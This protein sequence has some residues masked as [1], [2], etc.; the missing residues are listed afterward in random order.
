MRTTHGLSKSPEYRAWAGMWQRCA[1]PRNA[2]YAK[3]GGRGIAICDRWDSFEN[4]LEDMGWR[5]SPSH[6]I[7]RVD[8]NGNY[9]PENCRW[10]TRSEQQRNR[11]PYDPNVPTGDAHWTRLDPER[12]RQVGRINIVRA[13]KAGEEN[14]RARLTERDV[15][16]IKAQIIAGASDVSIAHQ[17]GVRPGA[18]WFIRAG[19]HWR[20]VQNG[21]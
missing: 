10:A 14:G 18:I 4:F 5:P 1:N 9:E 20:H 19:K 17:F 3:Y 13:H 8:N 2:R 11:N 15:K 16:I 12:A 6:S 21:S 7:D